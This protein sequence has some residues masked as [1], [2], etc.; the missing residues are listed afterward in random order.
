MIKKAMEDKVLQLNKDVHG[1]LPPFYEL[2]SLKIEDVTYQKLDP[3]QKREKTFEAIRDLLVRECQIRPIVLVVEDLHWIDKSS[4]EFLDYLIG[5]LTTSKILLLL[6]YRPEYTHPWGSKSYYNR[7]GLDQLTAKS[8]TELIQAIL[9]VGEPVP[10]LRALILNRAAG[11]PLYM[12]E[13]THTLLENGSI[14]CK[15]QKCV[16]NKKAS[17]IQV[18]DTIQGIIAARM[19]RLEDDL[20]RTMQVASVIGRDFA[21]RILQTITGMRQGLKSYLLNLQG[22]EFI[23]EKR[24]FPELEYVFKHALTQEVAYNSLLQ[25]RRKEIHEKIAQAIEAIYAGRLEEFFEMLAYHYSKSEN[26]EK[27]HQY[28]KLSGDKAMK[29]YSNSEALQFYQE[30]IVSLDRMSDTEENKSEQTAVRLSMTGPM[31]YLNWPEGS[32]QNLQEGARLS[33]EL[34]DERSLANFLSFTGVYYAWK[35]GDLVCGIQYAEDSFKHAKKINDIDLM[36]PTGADLCLLC[37]WSGECRK[38]VDTAAEVIALLERTNRQSETSGRP[39]SL[40]CVLHAWNANCAAMLGNFDAAEKLLEKILD[41]ALETKDLRALAVIELQYGWMLNFKGDGKKATI[42][43]QNCLKYSEESQFS[44]FGIAWGN[45]GWSYLLLEDFKSARKYL[46]K[47][48]GF[49][50]ESGV[51]IDLSLFYWLL[52]MVHLESGDL[53]N[54][55]QNADEALKISQKIHQKWIEGFVWV[56]LGRIYGKAEQPQIEK[57]EEC[58]LQGIEILNDLK[59]K[60]LYAQGYHYLGE[61]YTHT[62]RQDNAREVLNKVEGMFQEMGMDYWLSKTHEMLESLND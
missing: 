6:L 50:I 60:S 1:V 47:G 11:N 27:A 40:Y 36:A 59:L 9:Q 42:H 3:Q 32:L 15:D 45:L 5:W 10:E 44:L 16:L 20:K 18:P 34:G 28:L 43:F 30:A 29:N 49:F 12:E 17:E 35:K 57:A 23:Y 61:L 53:K 25:K 31:L 4:E 26:P 62:G 33:K 7:I 37:W 54:A 46:D 2:L 14:Q 22:L 51:E 41:F 24:L 55:Q 39:Y 38:V 8:S 58:I 21:F 52:G 13:F 56:L 48:L 19:D